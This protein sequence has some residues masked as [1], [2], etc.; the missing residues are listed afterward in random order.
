M[1]KSRRQ[2]VFPIHFLAAFISSSNI[3]E[4]THK[5]NVLQNGLVSY[6]RISHMRVCWNRKNSEVVRE[7]RNGKKKNEKMLH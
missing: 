1:K 3:N 7:L 4:R 6:G 2:A 5:Q